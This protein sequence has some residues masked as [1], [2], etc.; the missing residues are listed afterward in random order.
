MRRTSLRN[1]LSNYFANEPQR[2]CTHNSWKGIL[3]KN[4]KRYFECTH[5]DLAA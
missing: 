4:S 3:R 2:G 1:E 5:R